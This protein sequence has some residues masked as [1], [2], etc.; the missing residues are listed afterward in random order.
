MI[1]TAISIL[2]VAAALQPLI[3]RD[4]KKAVMRQRYRELIAAAAKISV[5][6]TFDMR[7]FGDALKGARKAV[8]ALSIEFNKKMKVVGPKR[9]K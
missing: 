8:E 7:Q 2:L 3:M 1:F 5:K 4:L 9:D 6:I